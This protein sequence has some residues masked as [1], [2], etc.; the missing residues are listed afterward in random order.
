MTTKLE[1]PEDDLIQKFILGLLGFIL[2]WLF[3]NFPDF[4]EKSPCKKK[5]ACKN[6]FDEPE[7]SRTYLK[8]LRKKHKNFKAI[9]AALGHPKSKIFSVGELWWPTFFRD[10]AP[11]PPPA[12]ILV[13]LRPCIYYNFVITTIRFRI[14]QIQALVYKIIF[15]RYSMKNPQL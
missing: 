11:P 13:L 4:Y 9:L 14:S 1:L 2:K 10:V 8:I 15:I 7:K 3:L 12:T 6:C 5:K